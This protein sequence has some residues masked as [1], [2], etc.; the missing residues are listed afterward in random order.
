[1][2]ARMWSFVIMSIYV[3]R[4]DQVR[5][6]SDIL[7]CDSVYI[8]VCAFRVIPRPALRR[9]MAEVAFVRAC[10]HTARVQAS[11]FHAG[12]RASPLAF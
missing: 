9:E 11:T 1:M 6:D 8:F 2:V 12:V 5:G 3:K 4:V 10:S 7:C